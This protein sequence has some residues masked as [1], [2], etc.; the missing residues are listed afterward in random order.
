[1]ETLNRAAPGFF[2]M[3]QESAWHELLLHISR[4]T[5][6]RKDVLTLHRLPNLLDAQQ[7][8]AIE[9]KLRALTKATRLGR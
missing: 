9:D 6:Q 3:A 7:R 4:M 2:Y 8:P 1:V 5:D